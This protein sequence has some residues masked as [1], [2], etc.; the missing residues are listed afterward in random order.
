MLAESIHS[1]SGLRPIRLQ[2]VNGET[3]IEAGDEL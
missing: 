3:D 2:L 1:L